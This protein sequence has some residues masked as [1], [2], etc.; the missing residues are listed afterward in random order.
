MLLREGFMPIELTPFARGDAAIP[1]EHFSGP[2]EATTSTEWTERI[3]CIGNCIFSLRGGG[4]FIDHVRAECAPLEIVRTGDVDIEF[5]FRENLPPMPGYTSAT[6]LK[7]GDGCYE[8]TCGRVTY[9]VCYTPQRYVVYVLRDIKRRH[10]VPDPL[11]RFRDRDF[12]A[13]EESAAKDFI[14][15]V[16]GYLV[17][18]VNLDRGASYLH[19]CSFEKEERGIALVAWR[20]IGKTTAMLKL[21]GE[22][23]WKYLSD[24]LA[25]LGPPRTLS[26]SARRIQL[27][28]YNLLGEEALR[29]RIFS[30]R[31]YWDRCAW[32]FRR[33]RYG[34]SGVRRRVSPEDIFGATAVAVSAPLVSPILMERA[35]IPDFRCEF[36]STGELADRAAHI[37]LTELDPFVE[38]SAAL[39]AF[40]PSI[41]LPAPDVFLKRTVAVLEDRFA[42]LDVCRVRVPVDASPRVL[43]DYLQ[44]LLG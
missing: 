34:L 36:L 17:Q 39:R 41:G 26:R 14:Y 22:Y 11:R 32:A 3:Y 8:T 25:M 4:A 18:I 44:A 28:G 40:A 42:G 7:I 15:G 12:L 38:I 6:P 13:P 2:V 16:L 27:D 24:D 31:N 1:I 20:G 5:D 30:Q 29:R 35:D 33:Q 23:G 9:Q 37:V 10:N 21:V 19:A 43:A